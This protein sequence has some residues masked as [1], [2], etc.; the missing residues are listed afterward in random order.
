MRSRIK[1]FVFLCFLVLRDVRAICPKGF[2]DLAPGEFI[3]HGNCI[4]MLE[5]NSYHEAHSVNDK[6]QNSVTSQV[7]LDSRKI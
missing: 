3:K 4:L 2:K 7:Y 5:T 1:L 6:I